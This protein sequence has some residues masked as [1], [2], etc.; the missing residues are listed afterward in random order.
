MLIVICVFVFLIALLVS[1]ARSEPPVSNKRKST[2]DLSE[3]TPKKT[4][5]I[6]SWI[7]SADR[8]YA[9]EGPKSETYKALMVLLDEAFKAESVDADD[10]Q[11][12]SSKADSIENV[13]VER[14]LKGKALE[15]E[16]KTAAAKRLFQMNVDDQFDASLPYER[17]A[18]IYED[19]GDYVKAI[20]VCK[21]YQKFGHDPQLKAKLKRKIARFEKHIAAE[22]PTASSELS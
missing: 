11:Y 3:R 20:E 9:Q 5:N 13:L 8:I 14:N 21:A 18:I 10:I 12:I 2:V 16:G 6:S 1:A 7:S 15:K 19:D 4:K 17:L 22:A